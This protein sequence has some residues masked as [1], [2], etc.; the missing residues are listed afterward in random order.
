MLR[1]FALVAC[2]MLAACG[3]PPNHAL[4]DWARTASIAVDRPSLVPAGAEDALA[5]QAAL[6]GWLQALAIL[7]EEEGMPAFRPPDGT[8]PADPSFAALDAALRGAA[9]TPPNRGPMAGADAQD[10][11]R[12]LPVAI[13]AA[14]P[15]VQALVA[16]L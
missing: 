13:R 11:A 1:R 9:A 6:A 14:D 5:R 7:A 15:P 10:E 12:R 2:L 16:A 8:R 4:R 3:L